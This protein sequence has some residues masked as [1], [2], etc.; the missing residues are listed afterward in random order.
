M[1][2][3]YFSITL[4]NSSGVPGATMRS[5]SKISATS[6]TLVATQLAPQLRASIKALGKASP[7]ECS[8]YKSHAE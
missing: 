7:S 1:V 3:K 8:T 5:L 2:L 6:P 4:H